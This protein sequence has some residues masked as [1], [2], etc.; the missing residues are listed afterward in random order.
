MG[1][2]VEEEAEEEEEEKEE[3]DVA[4]EAGG[5]G[6][7][8]EEAGVTGAG[9]EEAGG[10]DVA[11]LVGAAV[12]RK[13]GCGGGTGGAAKLLT[14]TEGAASIGGTPMSSLLLCRFITGDVDVDDGEHSEN[15][16]QDDEE[17][18]DDEAGAEGWDS[19]SLEEEEE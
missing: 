11:V 17:E 18:E 14:A 5:E 8:A 10:E 6:D 16:P 9:E 2:E 19:P 12:M 13:F 1:R 3:E 15:A 7:E 4:V